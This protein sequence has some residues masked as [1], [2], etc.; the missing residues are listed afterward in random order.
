MLLIVVSTFA[1]CA[2]SAGKIVKE[3]YIAPDLGTYLYAISMWDADKIF[4]VFMDKEDR[5]TKKFAEAYADGDKIKYVELLKHKTGE[6]TQQLVYKTLYAAWGPETLDDLEKN[7]IGQAQIKQR[8]AELGHVP[9]GIVITNIKDA[10]FAGGIALAAG[11]KQ[12]WIS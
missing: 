9:E 3:I 8:L 7:E 5:Y 2:E 1:G 6:I 11:H 10:E 4:P 12:I